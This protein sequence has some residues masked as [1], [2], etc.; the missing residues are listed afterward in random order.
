MPIDPDLREWVEQEQ[1]AQKS[2]A[3]RRRLMAY[4][5]LYGLGALSVA[6]S[7]WGGD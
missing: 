6:Y 5:V 4:F 3:D 1:A 7:M 2:R